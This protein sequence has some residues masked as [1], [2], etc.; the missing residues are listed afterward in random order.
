MRS[1]L[2]TDVRRLIKTTADRSATFL[3][4]S[5]SVKAA[6]LNKDSPPEKNLN[7]EPL[8]SSICTFSLFS[9]PLQWETTTT[10]WVSANCQKPSRPTRRSH[11]RTSCSN[12]RRATSSRINLSISTAKRRRPRR[13]TLSA[14]ASGSIRKTTRWRRGWT[15]TRVSEVE[16]AKHA[17]IHTHMNACTD[18]RQ[19]GYWLEAQQKGGRIRWKAVTANWPDREDIQ[20]THSPR[21]IRHFDRKAVGKAACWL[22]LF[23]HSV[24]DTRSYLL[25]QKYLNW[26]SRI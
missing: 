9:C 6:R 16:R 20:C 4:Q 10:S 14:T 23:L 18:V 26:P 12:P 13:S 15:K 5:V 11:Y 17:H 7:W 19:T 25:A 2:L 1:K 3:S 8:M 24:F 22:V 21:F